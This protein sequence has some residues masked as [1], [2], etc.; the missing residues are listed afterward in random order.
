MAEW[1]SFYPVSTLGLRANIDSAAFSGHGAAWL[2]ASEV[3]E[4]AAQLRDFASTMKNSSHL[5]GG[6]WDGDITE[7]LLSYRAGVHIQLAHFPSTDASVK[8]VS[9]VTSELTPTSQKIIDFC[10]D[11]EQLLSNTLTEANLTTQ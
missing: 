10:N 9:K 1:L 3:R 11:M 4:L 8:E 6:H 2:N 7:L 5:Q